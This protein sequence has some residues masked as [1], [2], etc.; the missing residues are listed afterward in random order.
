VK[1]WRLLLDGTG[2]VWTVIVAAPDP[3]MAFD[4]A[5]RELPPSCREAAALEELEA[6]HERA[7]A[8]AGVVVSYRGGEAPAVRLRVHRAPTGDKPRPGKGSGRR[9]G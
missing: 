4:L 3:F 9:R 5:R 1:L 2:I 6:L 7:P 8:G